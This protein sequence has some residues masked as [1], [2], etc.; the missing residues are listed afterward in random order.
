MSYCRQHLFSL[1][2]RLQRNGF[3]IF[4]TKTLC[5]ERCRRFLPTKQEPLWHKEQRLLVHKEQRLLVT[6]F[7]TRISGKIAKKYT[8]HVIKLESIL[9]WQPLGVMC[10]FFYRTRLARWRPSCLS[11]WVVE[12][13][14]PWVRKTGLPRA[15][16][17][18]SPSLNTPGYSLLYDD[19]EFPSLITAGL[20]C[21]CWAK[22]S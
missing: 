13:C 16:S 4:Y 5:H 1:R 3:V 18:P 21:K 22:W 11:W 8:R 17:P 20:N 10:L 6:V 7:L 12:F 2:V 9:L 14:L 15:P 19:S